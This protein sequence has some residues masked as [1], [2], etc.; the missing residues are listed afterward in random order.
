[1]SLFFCLKI[2]LV[3]IFEIF[4]K[5]LRFIFYWPVPRGELNV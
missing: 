5:M 2:I 4:G 3:W 1:M